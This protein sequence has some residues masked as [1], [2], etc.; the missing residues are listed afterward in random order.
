MN[1]LTAGILARLHGEGGYL[2]GEQLCREFGITRSAIWKHIR[3]LRDTGC[4]IEAAP[5][6]GYRLLMLSGSPVPAEVA[7]FLKTGFFGRVVY[8]RE[9]TASTN[10]LAKQL[11]AEGVP[12][13]SVVTADF[14]SAGRGRLG[15][16]WVSPAGQNLYFSVILRPLV[17]SYRVPQITLLVAAAIHRALLDAIPGIDAQ[18]KWPND[19][20]IGGK[21]LCG[22]LCEMQADPDTT[23]FVVAGIGI[24]VSQSRFAP[25]L[26]D[27]AT[28][29]YRETGIHVCRPE[30]LAGVLNRFEELYLQWLGEESLGFILPHLERHSLLQGRE[31]IVEQLNRRIAGTVLGI[32]SGGELLLGIADG[33]ELKITSGEAS[34]GS[35]YTTNL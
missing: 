5:G 28:S 3:Q 24:N 34:L 7:L 15:R 26:Q 17:A 13:G 23:H 35:T 27:R 21:K 6:S 8:Y 25:D 2:S 22:V 9:E 30:L 10:L 16:S 18:I 12:E 31:V 14:Q 11:A 4:R 32:A 19:I 29:L 20:L 1:D 33:T